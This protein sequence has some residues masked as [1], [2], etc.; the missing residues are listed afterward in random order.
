MQGMI[1][2]A[3][4]ALFVG[5]YILLSWIY[6]QVNKL[7]LLNQK[8]FLLKTEMLYHILV[9]LSLCIPVRDSLL[10]SVSV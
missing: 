7:M 5:I 4:D 2:E 10:S 6:F 8:I 9:I 1:R 3:T